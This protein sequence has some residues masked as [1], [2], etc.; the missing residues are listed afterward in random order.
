VKRRRDERRNL[1]RVRGGQLAGADENFSDQ[2]ILGLSDQQQQERLR[3]KWVREI[4]DMAGMNKPETEQVF[5]SPGS[6]GI[7][8]PT[9]GAAA[10]LRH[11]RHHE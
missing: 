7:R 5:A 9:G 2:T 4:A 11:F 8:T 10:P 6:S 3:G 1:P